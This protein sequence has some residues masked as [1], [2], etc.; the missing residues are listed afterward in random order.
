MRR[1][2]GEEKREREKERVFFVGAFSFSPCPRNPCFLYNHVNSILGMKK[3]ASSPNRGSS[4]KN[5]KRCGSA[6]RAPGS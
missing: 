4:S 3:F 5:E 6:A 1:G 2:R